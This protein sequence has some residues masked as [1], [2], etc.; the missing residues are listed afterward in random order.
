MFTDKFTDEELELISTA[1]IEEQL[2][3]TVARGI[4]GTI[5][6]APHLQSYSYHEETAMGAA[7]V[8]AEN[9]EF[10]RDEVEKTKKTVLI[11]KIGK[12]FYIS[13]EAMLAAR[14]T[15]YPLDTRAARSAARKVVEKEEETVWGVVSAGAGQSFTADP[16]WDAANAEVQGDV[17]DIRGMLRDYN[18][19][20]THLIVDVDSYAELIKTD[21]FGNRPIDQL[22]NGI[23]VVETAWI[24]SAV[25]GGFALDAS[26]VG[27]IIAEDLQTEGEYRLVNQAYH[28]QVFERFASVVFAANAIV[29]LTLHS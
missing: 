10:P 11:E 24:P 4:F 18:Y 2:E 3:A 19:S 22:P 14:A 20:F 16:L 23:Q 25:K 26:A 28:N 21:S 1:I 12:A 7:E 17:V 5:N 6:V 8:V 9:A 29:K 13:R 27:I 15:N